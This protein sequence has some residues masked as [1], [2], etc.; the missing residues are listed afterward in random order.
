MLFQP[1]LPYGDA[2]RLRVPTLLDVFPVPVRKI[3]DW[4]NFDGCFFIH[5]GLGGGKSYSMVMVGAIIAAETGRGLAANF[6]LDHIAIRA[7]LRS[8]GYKS[9]QMPV[10]Q[11]FSVSDGDSVFNTDKIVI[12]LD[13]VGFYFEQGK[14]MRRI[15]LRNA[16]MARKRYQLWICSS[17]ELIHSRY[18]AIFKYR[19]Y[20]R[21]LFG[22]L[23]FAQLR[24]M[25]DPVDSRRPTRSLATFTYVLNPDVYSCYD[26]WEDFDEI[27]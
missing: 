26:S 23:F 2:P 17:Q 22:K 25:Q 9:S 1:R 3:L 10:I 5:G 16:R 15:I 12:L 20:V 11:Q 8:L 13:E 19:L 14:T 7:Y 18:R 21:R 24:S 27:D 6:P 4:L